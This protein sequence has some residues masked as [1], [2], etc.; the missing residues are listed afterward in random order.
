MREQAGRWP[1]LTARE[2]QVLRLVASGYRNREIARILGIAVRTVA[3]HRCQLRTKLGAGGAAEL[4]RYALRSGVVEP[5]EWG[6]QRLDEVFGQLTPR[7]IEVLELVASGCTGNQIAWE[8]G[9]SAKT[10]SSHRTSILAKTG[11]G[12]TAR[13]VRYAAGA[14]LIPV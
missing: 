4:T 13:L 2:T 14:G 6:L 9:I 10:V 8:L 5:A 1:A 7:E 11:S 3:C 12:N